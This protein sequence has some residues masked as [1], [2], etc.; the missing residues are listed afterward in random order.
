MGWGQ[1]ARV[2][3]VMTCRVVPCCV[4]LCRVAPCLC[5]C[6]PMCFFL[7]WSWCF[8]WCVSVFFTLFLWLSFLFFPSLISLTVGPP[9]LL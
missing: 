3:P 9:S 2:W 6:V 7:V 4:A 1:H 8:A 5:H